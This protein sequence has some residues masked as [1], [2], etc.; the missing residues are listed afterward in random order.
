MP[1]ISL[2][3]KM[4]DP[5]F[6][7]IFFSFFPSLLSY[8]SCGGYLL[9]SVLNLVCV[10]L[11]LQGGVK[12]SSTSPSPLPHPFLTIP[13]HLLHGLLFTLKSVRFMEFVWEEVELSSISLLTCLHLPNP[14]SQSNVSMKRYQTFPLSVT[15]AAG[16]QARTAFEVRVSETDQ[17]LQRLL[18]VTFW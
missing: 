12:S 17:H 3:S 1:V 2:H 14:S 5:W 15:W 11:T 9:S 13:I 10:T 18:K 8:T 16:V 6:A 7:N 4:T